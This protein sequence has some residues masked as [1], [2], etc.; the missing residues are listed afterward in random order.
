M[1]ELSFSRPGVYLLSVCQVIM[2]F[3]GN[4]RLLFFGV[5]VVSLVSSRFW[6]GGT[7]LCYGV[8]ER[9]Y[10]GRDGA[11]VSRDCRCGAVA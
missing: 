7:V 4:G 9:R 6:A 8:G 10:G 2:A 5:G 3:C 1:G 11:M